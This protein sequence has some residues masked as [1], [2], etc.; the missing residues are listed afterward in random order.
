MEETKGLKEQE[1]MK[2]FASQSLSMRGSLWGEESMQDGGEV[3]MEE[4]S[5]APSPEQFMSNKMMGTLF[6]VPI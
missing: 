2:L 6:S 4:F 5:Y 1:I 3:I